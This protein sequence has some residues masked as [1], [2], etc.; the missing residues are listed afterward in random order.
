M[1][2][3]G[4]KS[5]VPPP[6]ENGDFYTDNSEKGYKYLYQKNFNIQF[7]YAGESLI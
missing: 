5:R 7:Q 3:K 6:Y 1:L 2:K 4:M